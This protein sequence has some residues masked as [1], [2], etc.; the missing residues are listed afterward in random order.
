MQSREPWSLLALSALIKGRA[1]EPS[2]SQ[3]KGVLPPTTSASRWET[4]PDCKVKSCYTGVEALHNERSLHVKYHSKGVKTLFYESTPSTQD[5][6]GNTISPTAQRGTGNAR[7]NIPDASKECNSRVAS[8]YSRVLFKCIPGTQSVR[9]VASSDRFK[10]TKSTNFR[11]SL[12]Y[13]R[14]KLSSEYPRKRRLCIQNGS[15]GCELSCTDP[16]RQQEVPPVCF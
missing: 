3:N 1:E 9:R 8:E 6:L 2:N 7:A 12:S 10:M 15:A 11:T 14:Y 5:P 4:K 16:S 13:V